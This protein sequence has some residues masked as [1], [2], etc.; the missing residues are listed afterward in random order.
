[1]SS[2]IADFN[3]YAI[4]LDTISVINVKL[5]MVVL[6]NCALPIPTAFTVLG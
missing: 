3:N 5:C 1:M 4:L 6:L 2:H